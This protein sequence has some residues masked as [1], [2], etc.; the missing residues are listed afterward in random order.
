MRELYSGT[1][2]FALCFNFS[3]SIV[4]IKIKYLLLS[5]HFFQRTQKH[6]SW[7]K[8]QDN[9]YLLLKTTSSN[10]HMECVLTKS[11]HSPK[12][13]ESRV[14]SGLC[15]FL[16]L[17]NV[18][19]L[20]SFCKRKHIGQVGPDLR[21]VLVV[22]SIHDSRLT[23]LFLMGDR[24]TCILQQTWRVFTSALFNWGGLLVP[25]DVEVVTSTARCDSL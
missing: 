24:R 12:Y 13:F 15:V 10:C 9:N 25:P 19:F 16:C 6:S 17:K 1:L 21:F 23:F 4:E 14:P 3:I 2:V 22:M 7:N 20:H 8:P 11:G 5:N 18:T